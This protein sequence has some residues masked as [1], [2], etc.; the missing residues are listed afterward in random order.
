MVSV[1]TKTQ[2]KNLRKKYKV[3]ISTTKGCLTLFDKKTGLFKASISRSEAYVIPQFVYDL[4]IDNVME[5]L[6]SGFH[7]APRY[8]TTTIHETYD[9]FDE[10]IARLLEK[11]L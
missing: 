6:D 2:E 7:E 1:M 8:E 3:Y 11:V 10:A 9:T 4:T 5:N